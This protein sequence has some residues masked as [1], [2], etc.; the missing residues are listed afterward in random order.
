R[1][2]KAYVEFLHPNQK[3]E[4]AA[5]YIRQYGAWDAAD[6]DLV[7]HLLAHS[8][9]REIRFLTPEGELDPAREPIMP[10]FNRWSAVS[11]TYLDANHYEAWV[12]GRRT[13]VDPDG[14]CLFRA[15]LMGMNQ[16][17]TSPSR[18][19]IQHLRNMAAEELLTHR[20]QYENF[21]ADGNPPGR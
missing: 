10:R 16:Q 6:G 11:V 19:E 4:R 3:I 7:P 17:T 1:Y 12:N 8:L 5:N 20:D 18:S 21:I 9:Q 13:E 2:T 15:V 14:N